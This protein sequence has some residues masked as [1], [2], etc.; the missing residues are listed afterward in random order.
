M[1]DEYEVVLKLFGVVSHF[2]RALTHAYAAAVGSSRFTI[3]YDIGDASD[4]SN[5]TAAAL[6]S[7][8]R[9]YRT[10]FYSFAGVKARFPAM[11][12]RFSALS[13]K[14][15]AQVK[16]YVFVARNLMVEAPLVLLHEGML[17]CTAAS[18]SEHEGGRRSRHVWSLEAD[19]AFAGSVRR[20]FDACRVDRSDLLSTGFTIAGSRWWASKL[21]TIAFKPRFRRTSFEDSL[22][23][24]PEPYCNRALAM[25]PGVVRPSEAK[26]YN[27]AVRDDVRYAPGQCNETGALFRLTSVER[28]VRVL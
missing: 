17:E 8:P 6:R 14:W 11:E 5:L 15:N 2:E 19:A 28:Y 9:A 22:G 10:C 23:T 7:I 26:Y 3:L 4:S 25:P 1:G 20:F 16:R 27:I 13:R 18:G 21:C 24:L 12:E